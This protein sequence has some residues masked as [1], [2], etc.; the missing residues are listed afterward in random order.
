MNSNI[1]KRKQDFANKTLSA[2]ELAFLIEYFKDFNGTKAAI[3]SGYAESSAAV[4]ACLILQ[5]P[6]VIEAF[7]KF[8]KHLATRFVNS[9][10]RVMKELSLLAYSDIKDY[11]LVVDGKTY[12]KSL[13]ALPPQISRAIK[14]LKGTRTVKRLKSKEK[15]TTL[16]EEETELMEVELY[17]KKLALELIG[18]EMGLFVDRKELT[19]KNGADLF[20]TRLVL[21]FGE[22]QK[23]E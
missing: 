12:I 4:S 1:K 15:D 2:R 23:A 7:E 20:P 16:S 14:K 8:E 5:R 6:R 13:D 19:G 3:R 10:E 9:K 21:D 18:K 11:I 17:D 22:E